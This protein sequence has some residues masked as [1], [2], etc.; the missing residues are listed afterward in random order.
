MR[1]ERI[2]A[3]NKTHEN[4]K[5]PDEIAKIK[6]VLLYILKSNGG[7]QDFVSLVKK[8]YFAQQEYL[9]TYGRPLCN[10]SFYARNRG[11]VPS[12][13]YKSLWAEFGNNS[14]SLEIQ[15]FNKSFSVS[16][17]GKSRNI[18]A[19][20]D[21]DMDELAVAEVEMLDVVLEKLKGLTAEQLTDMSHKDKAW[22]DAYE[23]T[24]DDP[25]RGLMSIMSIARSGGAKKPMLDYIRESLQFEAWC[26][27]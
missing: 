27:S 3:A 22:K 26:R 14:C 19:L 5:S 15:D 11:P 1:N 20:E 4:M 16:I 9:V 13:T 24:K 6:A 7:V 21:P 2:F 25:E 12:F 18:K 23:Q 10:D 17:S 8:M